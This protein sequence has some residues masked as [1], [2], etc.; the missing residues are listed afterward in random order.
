MCAKST[1]FW[2]TTKL[3]NDNLTDFDRALLLAERIA[4][5]HSDSQNYQEPNDY[6]PRS[7]SRLC[8]CPDLAANVALK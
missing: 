2:Y 8:C 4:T 1:A 6:R 5:V 7:N 3:F